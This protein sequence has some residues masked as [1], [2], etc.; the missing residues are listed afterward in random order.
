VL[1]YQRVPAASGRRLGRVSHRASVS[2]YRSGR[3]RA[4]G[5]SSCHH[6]AAGH[7][8][9]VPVGAAVAAGHLPYSKV[10]INRKDRVIV[11]NVKKMKKNEFH[12]N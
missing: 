4:S 3:W 2:A 7:H 12:L 5:R 9:A 8:P 10:T 1:S 11:Q 6:A